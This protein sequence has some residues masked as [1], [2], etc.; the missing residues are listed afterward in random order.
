MLYEGSGCFAEK[1]TTSLLMQ[2][3]W[4]QPVSHQRCFTKANS[5][6]TSYKSY[7]KCNMMEYRVQK[8]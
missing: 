3:V 6:S 8:Q 2:L 7:Q 5:K 4:M 1:N